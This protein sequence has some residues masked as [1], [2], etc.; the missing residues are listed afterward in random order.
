MFTQLFRRLS[1]SG[2]SIRRFSMP[3]AN[4]KPTTSES[5]L[6]E[7][8]KLMQN[9]NQNRTPI[10][11]LALFEWMINIIRVQP[12]FTSYVHLIQACVVV[13]HIETCRK[14][15][16]CI[17]QDKKLSKEEYQQLQIKLIYMYAR[18]KRMA[19]AEEIFDRIQTIQSPMLFGTIFKGLLRKDAL[20]S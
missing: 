4:V 20:Q 19:D 11:T 6:F 16:R 15:H 14:L 13:N 12:N 17:D 5:E 9:Y 2:L 7:I 8:N 10:R 1:W 18:I 3:I